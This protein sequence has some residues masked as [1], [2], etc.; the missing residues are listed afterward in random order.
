MSR[1]GSHRP[2]AGWA[3]LVRRDSARTTSTSR[4]AG[5]WTEAIKALRFF[6]TNRLPA[7]G[8]AQDAMLAA[9]PVMAHSLL[10]AALNLGLGATTPSSGA[11]TRPS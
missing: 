7:F 2:G 3:C 8:P 6:V 11:G 9:D 1:T 5:T 10:S 4:S